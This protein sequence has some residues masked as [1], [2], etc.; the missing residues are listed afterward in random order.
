[1]A[2]QTISK[3]DFWAELDRLGEEQVRENLLRKAYGDV[4]SKHDFVL[5]WLRVKESERKEAS[6]SE[7]TEIARSAKDAAW[8]AAE[9][10][11]DAAREAKTANTIAKT[12]L[13]IAIIAIVV[14]IV[15]AL[16]G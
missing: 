12:A 11:R 2:L 15:R 14:S 4:G 6:Q 8:A 5:E 7:Q 10:A 9:A 16:Y 13:A 1:M 3:A